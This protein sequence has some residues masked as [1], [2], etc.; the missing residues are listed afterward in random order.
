MAAETGQKAGLR[1]VLFL[2]TLSSRSREG[3]G[4]EGGDQGPGLGFPEAAS[5]GRRGAGE[6]GRTIPA[7]PS[8]LP[9]P[10]GQGQNLKA[11]EHLALPETSRSRQGDHSLEEA[12]RPVERPRSD[13]AGSRYRE[14]RVPAASAP[15]QPPA[16]PRRRA[17]PRSG[18][19]WRPRT[20]EVAWW[21]AGHRHETNRVWTE[22]E[23]RVQEN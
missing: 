4:V 22:R 14:A 19:R 23:G 13:P 17:L 11:G 3:S 1:G 21:H 12:T 7:V 20:G 18:S 10:S 16:F 2:V 5:P 9:G 8:W 15:A 6:G